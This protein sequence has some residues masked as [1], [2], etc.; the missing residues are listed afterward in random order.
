MFCRYN[1]SDQRVRGFPH[2]QRLRLEDGCSDQRGLTNIHCVLRTDGKERG[3][4]AS[5]RFTDRTAQWYST[6]LHPKL[7]NRLADCIKLAFLKKIWLSLQLSL[8]GV[9]I[10]GHDI[11]VG[12][13]TRYG[14]DGPWIESRWGIIFPHPSRPAWG[15]PSFLYNGYRVFPGVK[16]PGR[17]V[18]HA[19]HLVPRLKKE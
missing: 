2:G 16:R 6:T 15:P 18:D 19:P 1:M 10:S 7:N 11:S 3:R 8:S 13:A 12:I 17:G 9:F 5:Y 14:L 4:R